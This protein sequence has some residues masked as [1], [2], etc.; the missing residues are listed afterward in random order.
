MT[1]KSLTSVVVLAVV[2]LL[3]VG[4]LASSQAEKPAQERKQLAQLS[5]QIENIAA[6][7]SSYLEDNENRAFFT[8]QIKASKTNTIVLREVLAAAAR[9][10]LKKGDD[11]L[12]RLAAGVQ[13]A[14]IIM[15][16]STIPICRLDLTLPVEE[17]RVILQEYNTMYVAVAALADEGEVKSITAYSNGKRLTLSANEP[18]KI[19]TFVIIPAETESLDPVYPLTILREPQDETNKDRIVDDFVGIPYILITDDHE[20]WWKGR[21]EIEVRFRTWLKQPG[22]FRYNKVGL[23]GVNKEYKWY[24]LGDP[25]GTYLYFG[26]RHH[27]PFEIAVWERDSGSDDFLG[28]FF[29]HWT[30]LPYGGYTG[31][32]SN[33]DARI[34]VD[35]D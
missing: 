25:S 19:P 26:D 24:W 20:P 9:Q 4:P 33:G 5:R 21:P 13:R 28:V 14:E 22:V 35:R 2:G 34:Y 30:S 17:H 6:D 7:F 8:A 23:G 31:P 15:K 11:R 18:P 29:I 27:S 3:A 1:I 10:G 12:F 32:V 16:N